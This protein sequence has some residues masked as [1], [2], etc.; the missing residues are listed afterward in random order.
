MHARPLRDFAL[1][2]TLLTGIPLRVS[3]PASS[4]GT[5]QCAGYFPLVGLALGA[6]VSGVLVLSHRYFYGLGLVGAVLVIAI[7]AGVTRLLH[8]DGLADVADAWFVPRERRLAVMADSA[9]GAFGATCIVLVALLEVFALA[10]LG[11]S[12]ATGAAA[13]LAP[14]SGRLAAT[15]AA[16]LGTPARPGGLGS[17]VMGRPTVF[18]AAVALLGVLGS[19]ALA[20]MLGAPLLPVVVVLG[21]GVVFALA[22]PHVVAHRMGGVTGDTMGASVLI[23]EA[24]VWVATLAVFGVV[25]LMGLSA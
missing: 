19:G 2:V 15:F 12:A 13:A 1:A 16:W 9:I 6:F 20:R 11:S 4:G 17:S 5:T 21:A 10:S 23:V 14:V 22:V 3:G 24:G 7:L 18:S 25:R 8:W